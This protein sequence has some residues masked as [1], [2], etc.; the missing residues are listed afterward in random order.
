MK[1]ISWW[2]SKRYH[3]IDFF[4]GSRIARGRFNFF[5]RGIAQGG[6]NLSEEGATEKIEKIL[7]EERDSWKLKAVPSA[8]SAESL[9]VAREADRWALLPR[10]PDVY[11]ASRRS[12]DR[13]ETL[14]RSFARVSRSPHPNSRRR[15]RARRHDIYSEAEPH[16]PRR[17]YS[18]G[19]NKRTGDFSATTY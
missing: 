8:K 16:A 11:M 5:G 12:H 9:V 19:S 2:P 4:D 7:S 14:S 15:A 10:S 18:V 3:S 13:D 1:S 17:P 6:S